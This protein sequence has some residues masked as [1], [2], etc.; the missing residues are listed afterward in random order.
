M[1]V[2]E[3]NWSWINQRKE[4]LVTENDKFVKSYLLLKL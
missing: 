3:R 2:I 1:N 4:C